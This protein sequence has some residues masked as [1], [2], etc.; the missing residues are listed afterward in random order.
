MIKGKIIRMLVFSLMNLIAMQNANAK[1]FILVGPS[2]VGKTTLITKLKESELQVDE[3]LS[4]TTRKRRIEEKNGKDY[5]FVSMDQYKKL[6]EN[7]EFILS[8]TVHGNLYGVSKKYLD[9]ALETGRNIVCSFNTE[10]TRKLKALYGEKVVTVFIA[11]PSQAELK[12]RLASR[13][14]DKAIMNIRLKNAIEELKQQN[15]F[16]YKIVNDDIKKAFSELKKVFFV[17]ATLKLNVKQT[18]KPTTDTKTIRAMSY[19]IRMSPCEED[20]GTENEWAYRLPKINMVL[21]QYRPDII[22]IQE[23]SLEQM[24]SLQ[25]SNYNLPYK[26]LG[27]YPTKKPIESG[28]GIIY[29]SKKLVQ[30]SNLHAIW[31]NESQTQ[32]DAPAWD[33]S[34]YE[35]FVIYAKF[36]N[37]STRKDFWMITTHFD[38][39][40]I[41]ARS[42]SAEIIMNLAKKLDAPTIITGDFNCFPQAGGK[43][44]YNLLSTYSSYIKDSGQIAKSTFGVPGSWIGWDYDIYKQKEGYAKYDF[45]FVKDISS[46]S[47]QGIIDDKVW[48]SAFHKELYPSDHRPVFS[49]LEI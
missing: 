42:K 49:D 10:A 47:Q 16:E 6:Y 36:Y 22:G 43:E 34:S 33:G 37:L 28:L 38:H 1:I 30:I 29:N 5:F 19:N 31:L 27:Q 40:G 24:D 44:L 21:N 46:I 41:K 3:L 8:T 39:L 4:H 20:Q 9:K 25:K 26:F 15:S 12:K 48:D 45:V 32:S 17:K 14:E 35:R 13:G 11:P 2:G 23:V 7:N 18:V